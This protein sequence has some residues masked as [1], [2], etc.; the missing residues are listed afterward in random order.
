MEIVQHTVT[1]PDGVSTMMG[2]K[3]FQAK[4]MYTVSLE[5]LVPEDNF[6]RRLE[7]LLDLRFLYQ[8][9]KELYGETG[10][11]SIDPVVF[12]KLLLYGYFENIIYDRELVR[13]AADSLGVRL[14]LGYDIDEELPW[15]STVSRTRALLREEVF[16]KLFTRIV[17]Q[18][19]DA[20]LVEGIHQSVDS[21]LVK[22]NASLDS[23]EPRRA[24][25]ELREYIERTQKEN[26]SESRDNEEVS[27]GETLS[28]IAEK[29]Q[30]KIVETQGAK[31]R[32]HCSNER[33]RSRTDPDSRI[34][35]K[36]G[37]PTDLYYSTHYS[38]DRKDN[39]IT[40]VLTTSADLSD[41]KS[42][43]EII[44]RTTERLSEVGLRVKDVS[45]DRNY[46][47]GENLRALEEQGIRPFIPSQRHPNTTGGLQREEFRYDN[48]RDVYICPQG[49]DLVYSFTSKKNCRVYSCQAS[50]CLS[51]PMK[52]R[53]TPGKK[54]RR[55]Q[56]SVYKEEYERLQERMNSTKGRDAMRARKTGPEPL[57][58]E[59]K[60]YHGLSKY[61]TRGKTKAQKT[62]YVIASVQN[63][64]RLLKRWKM[65]NTAMQSLLSISPEF[66]GYERVLCWYLNFCTAS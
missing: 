53:C 63:L 15:H 7:R 56:H 58:A 38:V 21:T 48:Q 27:G 50:N 66:L 10:N 3:R 5:D 65:V 30:L 16:E 46:C 40:D 39:V 35:Q 24:P 31:K 60:M 54:G 19:V 36:P 23:L 12:F 33:Y 26:K 4:L 17:R 49:K 37:T 25:L 47:S 29:R 9:C 14:Y 51:C 44:K 8:E 61:M 34:A 18:C 2:K 43:Q 64:K 1:L 57:F 11:P 52:D 6:Y 59:G 32:E 41:S 45:A 55:V 13:R 22:A 20:G 28:A 62:S 42:L